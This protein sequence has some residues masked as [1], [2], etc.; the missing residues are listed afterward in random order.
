M[1]QDAARPAGDFGDRFFRSSELS[2]QFGLGWPVMAIPS[3]RQS[4]IPVFLVIT[5]GP[6]VNREVMGERKMLGKK[7][8]QSPWDDSHG[9]NSEG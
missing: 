2:D 1:A 8:L 6:D 9:H 5:P 3:F 4:L 7:V